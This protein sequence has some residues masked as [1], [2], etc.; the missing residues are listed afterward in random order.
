MTLTLGNRTT[1]TQGMSFKKGHNTDISDDGNTIIISGMGQIHIYTYNQSTKL[2]DSDSISNINTAISNYTDYRKILTVAVSGDGKTVAIGYTA[3]SAISTNFY[4]GKVWLYRRYLTQ[5]QLIGSAIDDPFFDSSNYDPSSSSSAKNGLTKFGASLS[6]S[7]DGN[8]V[9]IGAPNADYGVILKVG[10]LAVYNYNLTSWNLVN[11]NLYGVNPSSGYGHSISLSSNGKILAVSAIMEDNNRGI[12]TVFEDNNNT[13]SILQAAITGELILGQ[14]ILLGYIVK[15][16]G[17]GTKVFGSMNYGSSNPQPGT[18]EMV[19]EYDVLTG[20]K[21]VIGHKEKYGWNF[22]INLDGTILVA[23]DYVKGKI[24]LYVRGENGWVLNDTDTILDLN[25]I[26][27]YSVSLSGDGKTV[28]IGDPEYI[29]AL[30]GL[31]PRRE[32]I[33]HVYNIS[34][35]AV[36]VADVKEINLCY[37]K[38][39]GVN[40]KEAPGLARTLNMNVNKYNGSYNRANNTLMMKFN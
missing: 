7:Y 23:S 5:W 34:S 27:G 38:L 35:L 37:K 30:L 21:I 33:T 22:D 9:A 8:R 16:N 25:S 2:W 29:S 3:S 18:Y 28:V 11:Q 13:W 31:G 26:P 20:D 12:I 32:G 24:F 4:E 1:I 14:P 17:L 6:L 19:H 40:Q 15:L 39:C 10:A 36:A